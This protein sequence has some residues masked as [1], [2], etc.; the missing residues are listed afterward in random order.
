MLNPN[1]NRPAGFFVSEGVSVPVSIN[2]RVR[3]EDNLAKPV[4]GRWVAIPPFGDDRLSIK[5]I[6]EAVILPAKLKW[7]K[8]A[9]GLRQNLTMRPIF[10][11]ICF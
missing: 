4:S 2:S 10:W 9:S 6:S 11:M 7:A 1:E 5:S 3:A 8:P